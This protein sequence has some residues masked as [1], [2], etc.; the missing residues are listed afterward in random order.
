[1]KRSRYYISACIIGLLASLLGLILANSD[2]SFKDLVS[3]NFTFDIQRIK[4]IATY[5]FLR[6][7]YLVLRYLFSQL[8]SEKSNSK[9]SRR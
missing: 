9:I 8:A 3:F 1:M 4:E 2:V 6:C 5:I 7:L